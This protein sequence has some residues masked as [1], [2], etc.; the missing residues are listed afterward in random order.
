MYATPVVILI[1]ALDECENES[2]AG[3][4]FELLAQLQDLKV[5]DVRLFITSRPE[6]SPDFD[7]ITKGKHKELILHDI[8]QSTIKHD[9]SHFLKHEFAIIQK[10]RK[11]PKDWPGDDA[12]KALSERATPLF[13]FASVVCRFVA[14]KRFP[15]QSR[16]DII[17]GSTTANSKFTSKVDA[18]YEPVL[19]QLLVDLDGPEELDI[20]KDFGDILGTI[21]LLEAPLSRS[22]LSQLIEKPE[23]EIQCILVPIRSIL[24]TPDDS[25]HPIQIFH[26]SFPDFLLDERRRGMKFFVDKADAH[27]RIAI[28]C[29]EL[30]SKYLREDI[31]NLRAP[32][33][34]LSDISRDVIDNH[35]P[36]SVQYAC[37]YWLHHI[38]QPGLAL[39]EN[40]FHMLY[41]FLSKHLLH[42]LE[43]MILLGH[44]FHI[45]HL[46]RDLVLPRSSDDETSLAQAL[47]KALLMQP[48]I[49]K[50]APIYSRLTDL[51]NDII[52]F[53]QSNQKILET[54][55]L[56][57][58]SSSICFAPE[59]CSVKRLF[60]SVVP[61]WIL[62]RPIAR[63]NWDN[64]IHT[65]EYRGGYGSYVTFS[66]NGSKIAAV[67]SDK[68]FRM[69]D[70]LSGILVQTLEVGD[71]FEHLAFSPSA[72]NHVAF[73]ARSL[74]EIWDVEL[75]RQLQTF[76]TQR[77]KIHVIKFSPDGKILAVGASVGFL[78]LWNIEHQSFL[79]HLKGH[80]DI[81]WDL[82]FSSTG[83]RL[84]SA[85]NDCPARLWDVQSGKQILKFEVAP[86]RESQG[87][88]TVAFSSD[89]TEIILAGARGRL[90]ILDAASGALLR[91][92]EC[93][94]DKRAWPWRVTI[95]AKRGILAG[96]GKD[97]RIHVC[98]LRD[99]S[100]RQT[101][102]GHHN[103]HSRGSVAFSHYGDL[104]AS[105]SASD[106]T[107]RIWNI[108][109]HGSDFPEFCTPAEN[110]APLTISQD[111]KWLV[112]PTLKTI[113]VWD[114]NTGS[115][116]HSFTGHKF[117]VSS[118]AVS[119]DSKWL[120]SVSD[121]QRASALL[122]RL[123]SCTLAYTFNDWKDVSALAFSPDNKSIAWTSKDFINLWSCNLEWLWFLPSKLIYFYM[124]EP[125]DHL[126]YSPDGRSLILASHGGREVYIVDTESET[127]LSCIA[128]KD[129]SH[130]YVCG[131]TLSSHYLALSLQENNPNGVHIGRGQ[132]NKYISIRSLIHGEVQKLKG[133]GTWP[134]F[135]KDGQFIETEIGRTRLQ[136][137]VSLGTSDPALSSITIKDS[138][139]CL[140][141]RRVLLL[142][143]EYRPICMVFT[144]NLMAIKKSN[145]KMRLAPFFI[146][147]LL[148]T[149]TAAHQVITH[150]LVDDIRQANVLRQ[151]GTVS[152]ITNPNSGDLACGFP[153]GN[154]QGMK[155]NERAVVQPGSKLTFE[156][157]INWS[158]SLSG[159]DGVT[160]I[161]HK[162]PCAIY[163]RKISNSVTAIA[164]DPREPGW[165]KIWEDGVDQNG[166]FCT[167][168]M[169]NNGGVF[170]ARVPKHLEN[171][172]YLIR[173]ETITLNNA[174]EPNNQPQWYV[175][176]A[177]VTLKDSEAPFV[178]PETIP[179][180]GGDYANLNM[181]G[182]SYNIWY[183]ERD[184]FPDYGPVPGPAVF[185]DVTDKSVPPDKSAVDNHKKHIG[186]QASDSPTPTSFLSTLPD[187]FTTI[188]WPQSNVPTMPTDGTL[189]LTITITT[190]VRTI[191]TATVTITSTLPPTATQTQL[192]TVHKVTTK[193]VTIGITTTVYVTPS[194]PPSYQSKTEDGHHTKTVTYIHIV[195]VTKTVHPTG[196]RE[197]TQSTSSTQ[198]TASRP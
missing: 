193:T 163:M 112:S 192:P 175:G 39:D 76:R 123:E 13:I 58:Y 141:G 161:S 46:V 35:I 40:D 155:G 70:T 198:E 29:I 47:M 103:K 92:I 10:T 152:P 74:V 38:R 21:V 172:D 33:T 36:E 151:P 80:D 170:S 162:G 131:M 157:H 118:L 117:A 108:L 83:E 115:L 133:S 181:P 135:S 41:H 187:G 166:V 127:L 67:S 61:A 93:P 130:Q 184:S 81:I 85:C 179:I 23:D 142:A 12:I 31:C 113:E 27:K 63:L 149:T 195:S 180:P 54:A 19:N 134:N 105:P 121:P 102:R 139:F 75:G 178:Q 87:K 106:N 68:R 132:P 109:Y 111:S 154:G 78:A 190:N 177:Q 55:P 42:W 69:W 5:I 143:E 32:E 146:N 169:R 136:P 17:L 144:D 72:E 100:R 101:L 189:T 59:E 125:V 159:P 4:I 56:Q 182:L 65:L 95:V 62:R 30:L 168:R 176:C 140:N 79:Y 167:T 124:P 84:I 174:A 185:D 153:P 191:S 173:A 64:L 126:T 196:D 164:N 71:R 3:L 171:G 89:D 137:G 22:A 48:Q 7:G 73:S 57:L 8:Q 145:E 150:F 24:D 194:H 18:I 77:T 28:Y 98:D 2:D 156:W 53:V 90:L 116:S 16:L 107:I 197:E 99:G 165:F 43:A 25:N 50:S 120:L 119:Y 147:L 20:L 45:V 82:A 15:A 96:V 138:W 160:D 148:A 91:N 122:W 14:E 97:G 34:L 51:L 86:E 52:R 37:R 60:S 44:S 9:I 183:P 26:Q 94:W 1:D 114:V 66:P 188:P 186:T 129:L 49:I 128:T 11:M 6:I 104:L 88:L 110:L 158:G